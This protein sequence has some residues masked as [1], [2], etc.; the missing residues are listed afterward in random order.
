MSAQEDE[1]HKT[2]KRCWVS[3]VNGHELITTSTSGR[4]QRQLLVKGFCRSHPESVPVE[5]CALCFKWYYIDSFPINTI[6]LGFNSILQRKLLYKDTMYRQLLEGWSVETNFPLNHLMVYNYTERKNGTIR[7]NA[8]IEVDLNEDFKGDGDWTDEQIKSHTV[9]TTAKIKR[10]RRIHHRIGNVMAKKRSFLLLDERKITTLE[11]PKAESEAKTV[12]IALKYF[13]ILEQEMHFVDWLR[14]KTTSITF[15]DISKHIESKLIPNDESKGGCL[16]SLHRLNSEIGDFETRIGTKYQMFQFWEEEAARLNVG[17]NGDPL[18]KVNWFSINEMVDNEFYNGDIIVFQI[19]QSHPYFND[20]AHVDSEDHQDDTLAE[21]GRVNGTR[22][23]STVDVN[24]KGCMSPYFTVPKHQFEGENHAFWYGAADQFIDSLV[25]MVDVDITYR[26]T[27][28][29]KALWFTGEL[30]EKVSRSNHHWNV[31]EK[32]TFGMIR[33]RLGS[34]YNINPENIEIWIPRR[35]SSTGKWSWNFGRNGR[36]EWAEPLSDVLTQREQWRKG[37]PLKF[38]IVAYNVRDFDEMKQCH[39]TPP[40]IDE[41]L[42]KFDVRIQELALFKLHFYLPPSAIIPTTST[43]MTVTYRKNWTAKEFIQYIL[44]QIIENQLFLPVYFVHIVDYIRRVEPSDSEGGS[45]ED[46]EIVRN[47]SPNRFVIVDKEGMQTDYHMDDEYKMPDSYSQIKYSSFRV[48]FLSQNDPLTLGDA[49]KTYGL[50]VNIHRLGNNKFKHKIRVVPEDGESFKDLIL[51]DI[52][53]YLVINKMHS[54]SPT[55]SPKSKDKDKES[56]NTSDD[57]M[58]LII[59][60]KVVIRLLM[61]NDSNN[62]GMM[63]ANYPELLNRKNIGPEITS[64][65]WFEVWLPEREAKDS[66]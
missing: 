55:H 25:N 54:L 10:I 29:N 32:T 18:C 8:L 26:Q 37:W 63:V 61:H 41:S 60:S 21:H 4:H 62:K 34:Y 52:W 48:L 17:S 2:S 16:H 47:L 9:P 58:R 7:P 1:S 23:A 38:E 49:A 31:T 11:G 53:P 65:M 3:T 36:C 50:W 44:D 14:I 15:A 35:S 19:N 42:S 20:G 5:I 45:V 66:I 59:E 43:V 33:K 46:I 56:G 30:I 6:D 39:N 28:N 22:R 27:S 40:S 13:D 64:D 24:V 51:R 57:L 12:L